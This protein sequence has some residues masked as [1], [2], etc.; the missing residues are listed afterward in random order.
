MQADWTSYLTLRCPAPP[1]TSG[2]AV[3]RVSVARQPPRPGRGGASEV[4]VYAGYV[5]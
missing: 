5:V 3:L 4:A 1:A 2:N